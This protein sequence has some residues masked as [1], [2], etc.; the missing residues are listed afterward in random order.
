MMAFASLFSADPQ[1]WA[2]YVAA[3][4]DLP[5]ERLNTRLGRILLALASQPQDSIPQATGSWGQA[6]A[7]YRFLRNPRMEVE[8][9][10]QPL[11]DTTLD[12]IRGLPTVLAVQ[13][14]S[15]TNFS[16]LGQTSGLGPLNDSARARGLHLHTTLAVRPDGVVIGLLHQRCW[17]RPEGEH[18]AARRGERPL[19]DKESAKWLEGIE[20]AEA[21]VANLPAAERPRLIHVM[22]REGDIHE[23]LERIADSPHGAVIRCAQNRSVAG[24]DFAHQ[25]VAAAPCLGVVTLD[26]P[27]GHGCPARQ[28]RVE[29]RSANLT[30]TPDRAKH[31]QR[32]AVSWNL[33]EVRE[34]DA[35]AGVEAVHW[36]L[37][38]TEPAGTVAEVLALLAIYKLR[39]RVEDF[40]LALK[41]G[42]Q[43]EALALET[44][45]R[46]DKALVLYSAVAVRIVALR[47]LARVEP[48]APCTTILSPD[49]WQALYAYFE[50]RLPTADTPIPTVRQAIRWIARLGGHLARQG[51]GLPGVRTLWRGWRDL[52]LLSAGWRAAQAGP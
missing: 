46:L 51:D 17:S 24:P 31:P 14:S 18:T 27:A 19:Q 8:D 39:W 10:L 32:Q 20:A 5:D 45:D 6:K 50:H 49:R 42:C 28:A 26:L 48:E 9:F 21:A 44:A 36:L 7:V 4:A 2:S 11:V 47:D 13:D 23:V 43:V 33:V 1:V 52:N 41:S 35:P 37:W 29:L 30:V 38:T 3:Q 22:D 16:S 34:I 40:H 25:A 12:S 15:S